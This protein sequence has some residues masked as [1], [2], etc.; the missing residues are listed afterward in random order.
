MRKKYVFDSF[1]F[2]NCFV[3]AKPDS[4]ENPFCLQYLTY[5]VMLRHEASAADETDA[6]YLSMAEVKKRLER[7]A[8]LTP[9]KISCHCFPN[10]KSISF[11]K[12]I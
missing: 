6:S 9:Q 12:F 2:F 5:T 7:I 4:S 1:L 3:L 11:L 10:Q 8:G